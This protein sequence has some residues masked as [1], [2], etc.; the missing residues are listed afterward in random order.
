MEG[1]RQLAAWLVG[2]RTAIDLALRTRLADR[3]PSPA[4]PEAEALRRLRSFAVLSLARGGRDDLPPSL[5][6]LR[7]RERRVGPL[8][9]AWVEAVG[10]LAGPD[11]DAV[12]RRLTA[13]LARFRK[14]LRSTPTAVRASGAPRAGRRRAV[15]AAIDRVADAFLAIDADSGAIADA[16]PAAGALLG[17]TRDALL[18]RPVDVFVPPATRDHWWTELEAI[19]ETGEVRRFRAALQDVAGR[20]L[21]VEASISR[22]AT[23]S[24]TLALLLARPGAGSY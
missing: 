16:N 2:Q 4:S 19:T 15:S 14:A 1:D 5:E 6:G 21:P 12:V 8:L 18:G 17:T 13:V 7:V 3:M 24:R 11:G 10:T 20:E 23:R 22:F 9:E